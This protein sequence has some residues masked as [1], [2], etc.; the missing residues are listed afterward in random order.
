MP[1]DRPD[2]TLRFRS[3]NRRD[4]PAGWWFLPSVTLGL[5]FWLSLRLL[6]IG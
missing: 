6:L 5:I 4:L 3:Q 1:T 2:L